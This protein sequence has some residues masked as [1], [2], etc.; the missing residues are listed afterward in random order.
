MQLEIDV[1]H[2]LIGVACSVAWARTCFALASRSV[3]GNEG[4]VALN[5]GTHI[6]FNGV[7]GQL[8]LE[9]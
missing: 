8:V 3:G 7:S 4:F 6:V 1:L 9:E 2:H 5:I